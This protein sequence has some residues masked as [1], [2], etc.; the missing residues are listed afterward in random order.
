M[1]EL[2]SFILSREK[3][4]VI[5]KKMQNDIIQYKKNAYTLFTYVILK[6]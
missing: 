3:M 2:V 6:E 1:G 4:I 5:Y